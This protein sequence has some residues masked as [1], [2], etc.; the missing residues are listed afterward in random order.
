MARHTLGCSRTVADSVVTLAK[1]S[2]ADIVDFFF[3]QKTDERVS[4]PIPRALEAE[5]AN[6]RALIA[7]VPNL[8]NF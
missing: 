5:N 7:V 2:G 1:R 8:R 4:M 3:Y 6:L